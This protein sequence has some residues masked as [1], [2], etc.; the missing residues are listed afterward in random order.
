MAL[1]TVELSRLQQQLLARQGELKGLIHEDLT[2]VSHERS[3]GEVQDRGEESLTD[4]LVDTE[5]A[6]GDIELQELRDIEVALTGVANGGYGEC[7]VCGAEIPVARL[8][9]QPTAV[10]CTHCQS[11]QERQSGELTHRL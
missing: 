1:K 6:L 3:A 10:R 8:Q 4:L 7:I 11:E 2:T 5:L 9:S